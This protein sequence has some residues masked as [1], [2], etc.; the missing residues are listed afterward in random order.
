M[1]AYLRTPEGN[2]VYA[3]ILASRTDKPRADIKTAR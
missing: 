3:E 2:A 1:E